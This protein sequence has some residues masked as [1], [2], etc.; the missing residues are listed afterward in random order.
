MLAADGFDDDDET[1]ESAYREQLEFVN[2]RTLA[3]LDAVLEG[4]PPD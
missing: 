1:S 3:A 2:A 4:R